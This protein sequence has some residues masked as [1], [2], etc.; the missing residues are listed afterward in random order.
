MPWVKT[1]ELERG[2][3][4]QREVTSDQARALHRAGFPISWEGQ[5]RGVPLPPAEAL[6]LEEEATQALVAR[7]RQADD[8][9]ATFKPARWKL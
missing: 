4:C 8:L 3:W 6:R 2:E 7:Q 1:F 5:F 9:V